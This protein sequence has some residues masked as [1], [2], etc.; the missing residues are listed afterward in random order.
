VDAGSLAEAARLTVGIVL[1][2]SGVGKLVARRGSQVE[3]GGFGV[4]ATLVPAAA[5]AIPVA[6][7]VVALLVL[8]VPARWPVWLAVAA[9]ALF[10]GV[11]VAELQRGVTAPCRCFG[12]LSTR[13]MSTRALLRN[14]WFLALAVVATAASGLGDVGWLALPLLAVSAAL[15]LTT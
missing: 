8:V 12:S 15:I 3:L 1:V 13:P 7:L 2:V 5:L 4:P 11:V 14:T 10:T 9:F 6:E